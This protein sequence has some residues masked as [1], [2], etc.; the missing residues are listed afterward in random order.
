MKM[1]HQKRQ[2]FSS[3]LKRKNKG[4]F[5]PHSMIGSTDLVKV[6]KDGCWHVDE[7]VKGNFL[8]Q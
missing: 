1:S 2:F 5:I 8:L 4:A 3:L 7:Q 6:S